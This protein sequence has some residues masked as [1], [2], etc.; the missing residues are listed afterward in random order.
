MGL[1]AL[2]IC[3][4]LSY[5]PYGRRGDLVTPTPKMRTCDD[6]RTVLILSEYNVGATE[7]LLLLK[8]SPP[9]ASI[10]FQLLL[11]VCFSVILFKSVRFS[12]QGPTGEHAPRNCQK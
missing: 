11:S 8:I 5:T 3:P 10:S 9:L 6:H 7:I 1:R 2:N 12:V 4:Q